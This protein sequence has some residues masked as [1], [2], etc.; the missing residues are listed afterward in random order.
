[1]KCQQYGKMLKL[2]FY[3]ENEFVLSCK[4]STNSTKSKKLETLKLIQIVYQI[5]ILIIIMPSI[6]KMMKSFLLSTF[7]A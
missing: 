6:T 5:I 1:M 7:E 3:F 4:S 2:K